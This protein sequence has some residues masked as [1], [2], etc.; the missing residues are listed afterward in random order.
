MC[1]YP[2]IIHFL[3]SM[4]PSLKNYWPWT[5]LFVRVV[6]GVVFIM[7]GY[8]KWTIWSGIPQGMPSW[9]GVLFQVLSI[10]E[11]LAG[12]AILVGIITE[13]A[14]LALA[15]VMVGAIVFKIGMLQMPFSAGNA[16]GWEFDLSLLAL[17]VSL[18]ASGGGPLS[19]DAKMMTKK[20]KK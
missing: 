13:W 14:A 8:Q 11:P 6:L 9:L 3:F 1:Y 18:V 17:A 19:L 15:I 4:F 7:H 12:L 16:T 20:K 10:L 2:S 5:L